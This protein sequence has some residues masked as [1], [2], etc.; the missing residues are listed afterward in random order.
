MPGD[1]EQKQPVDGT[2]I[3]DVPSDGV[4]P[5][6][7]IRFH[8]VARGARRIQQLLN[9]G[10]ILLGP[11]TMV[12]ELISGGLNTRR[13]VRQHVP[14]ASLGRPIYPGE[15]LHA[16]SENSIEESEDSLAEG[17]SVYIPQADN[18]EDEDPGTLRIPAMADESAKEVR[19]Q[20]EGDKIG[21]DTPGTMEVKGL[22][23]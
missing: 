16:L 6:A 18:D 13:Q 19:R 15:D 3:I 14:I 23:R 20:P 17:R 12:E 4:G 2:P 21:S 22:R 5:Y 7:N 11:V 9:I 1:D 10:W 8:K